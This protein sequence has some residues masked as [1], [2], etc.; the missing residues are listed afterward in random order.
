[1]QLIHETFTE[2]YWF[3]LSTI[4]QLVHIGNDVER[5][6]D[7]RKNGNKVQCNSAIEKALELLELTIIDPQNVKRLSEI[8]GVKL[9]LL[10]DFRGK[11][12]YKST[13]E[14]WHKYFACFRHLVNVNKVEGN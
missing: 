4:E 12:E 6:I 7:L 14:S 2:N 11:N 9:T 8:H 5:A 10:D 1:M 13:D 3:G